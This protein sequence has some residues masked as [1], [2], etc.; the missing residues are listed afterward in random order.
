[1]SPVIEKK[2]EY[3]WLTIYSRLFSFQ[4]VSIFLFRLLSLG[5]QASHADPE[6]FGLRLSTLRRLSPGRRG[7]PLVPPYYPSSFP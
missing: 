3:V 4:Q 6:P 2:L 7:F 5:K 1:M